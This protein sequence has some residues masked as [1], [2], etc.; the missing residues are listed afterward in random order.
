MRRADVLVGARASTL[1]TE[2]VTGSGSSDREYRASRGE[3]S[4]APVTS[5]T[6]VTGSAAARAGPPG[7]PRGRRGRRTPRRLRR[8]QAR[9]GPEAADRCR[10]HAAEVEPDAAG[11]EPGVL[12]DEHRLV[13]DRLD[14]LAAPTRPPRPAVCSSNWTSTLVSSRTD[15]VRGRGRVADEV[16]E[17]DRPGHRHGGLLLVGRPHAPR[18]GH[19]LAAQRARRASRRTPAAPSR[20]CRSTRLTTSSARRP[21]AEPRQ[22]DVD[23]EGR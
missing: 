17:A 13:A 15:I 4:P 5:A 8:S 16:D 23:P 6:V 14:D 18:H 1:M 7:S 11:V 3:R 10:T 22:L 19:D 12:G 2:T 20:R 9:P 21:A